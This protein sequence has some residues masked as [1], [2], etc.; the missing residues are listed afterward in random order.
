MDENGVQPIEDAAPIEAPQPP[1]EKVVNTTCGRCGAEFALP[2]KVEVTGFE[3]DCTNCGA[4]NSV[5]LES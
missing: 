3:F 2:M 5:E 1:A 4:H